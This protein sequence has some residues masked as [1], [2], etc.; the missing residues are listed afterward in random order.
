M[1]IKTTGPSVLAAWI[2]EKDPHVLAAVGKM[3]EEASELSK[4]CFRAVVAGLTAPD[5]D[6]P[7]QT[8]LDKL[9]EEYADVLSTFKVLRS[10]I[11]IPQQVEK[12]IPLRINAKESHGLRWQQ[13]IREEIGRQG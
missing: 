3:G 2:P 1:S 13:L 4:A 6:N 9:I 11:S 5:H 8:N 12:D 10:V 7:E